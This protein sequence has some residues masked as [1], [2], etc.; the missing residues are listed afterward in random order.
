M[1]S[2]IRSL[3]RD[4]LENIFNVAETESSMNFYHEGVH[5]KQKNLKRTNGGA[6][7]KH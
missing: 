5:G 4:I 3:E 7:G 6:M 2:L 1:L